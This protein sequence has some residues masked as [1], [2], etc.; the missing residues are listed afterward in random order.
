[1]KHSHSPEGKT[2]LRSDEGN[3]LR[4]SVIPAPSG[5]YV[6]L[7]SEG[8]IPYSRGETFPQHKHIF[9]ELGKILFNHAYGRFKSLCLTK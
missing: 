3:S 6:T 5:V 4:Q 8:D 9:S 1:M 7:R 2:F